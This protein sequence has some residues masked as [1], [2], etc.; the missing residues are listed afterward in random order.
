MQQITNLSS[1]GGII[2]SGQSI[3]KYWKVLAAS[4]APS[5]LNMANKTIG[6]I[7]FT[8]STMSASVSFFHSGTEGCQV[9]L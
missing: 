2:I 4:C 8:N 6:C 5:L 9:F 1:N 7:V 3:D